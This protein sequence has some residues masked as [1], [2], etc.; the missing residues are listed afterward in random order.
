MFEK[1]KYVVTYIFLG[2][3]LQDVVEESEDERFEE[4][5]EQAPPI[6]LPTPEIG[7]LEE[8]QN[9]MASCL[10][11]PMRREKLALALETDFYIKKLLEV[12]RAAEKNEDKKALTHVYHIFRS[13]F[14]LNKNALF[15]IMFSGII[16]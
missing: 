2:N 6:E 15:E 5:S 14:L 11:V 8:L 3:V 1:Y 9:L 12:F 10:T 13:I 16:I 7:R 4:V